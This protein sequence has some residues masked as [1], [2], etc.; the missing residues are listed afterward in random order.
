MMHCPT[1]IRGN[2]SPNGPRCLRCPC[3]CDSAFKNA[4]RLARDTEESFIRV[5]CAQS[6]IVTLFGAQAMGWRYA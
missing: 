5:R 4:S 6:S 3:D 1:P 2:Q